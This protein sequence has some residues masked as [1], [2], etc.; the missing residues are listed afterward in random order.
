MVTLGPQPRTRD[1]VACADPGLSRLC[2]AL[3][4]QDT[5]RK[6]LLFA[7]FAHTTGFSQHCAT[8]AKRR[9]E[10]VAV[11]AAGFPN[12]HSS[13]SLGLFVDF[14]LSQGINVNSGRRVY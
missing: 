5:A 14:L 8:K 1:Q 13:G 9:S 10:P 11:A 6:Q 3:S 12:P 7:L 2:P 4:G